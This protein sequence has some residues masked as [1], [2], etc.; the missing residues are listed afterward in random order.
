MESKGK[1]VSKRKPGFV[2]RQQRGEMEGTRSANSIK[3]SGQRRHI[4]RTHDR[5]QP[6]LKI[7][8]YPLA[9]CGPSTHDKKISY[10]KL[11]L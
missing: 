10:T 8:Q 5:T 9:K 6:L 3:A 7:F 11:I 4:G 1:R 2:T